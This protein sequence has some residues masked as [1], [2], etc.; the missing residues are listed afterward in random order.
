MHF[1]HLPSSHNVYLNQ[2]CSIIGRGISLEKNRLQK[3][4]R[5]DIKNQ[6]LAECFNILGT[7]NHDNWIGVSKEHEKLENRNREDIYFYLD[8]D[9]RTR[10]FFVEGKRLPK[11]GTLT[12]EEYVKG[13]STT[14]NPSGG[15]ERFKLG[16]HG[17]PSQ[18]NCYG[19]IAYVEKNTIDS[20]LKIIN[21][22]IQKGFPSDTELKEEPHKLSD[23]F[24]THKLY[25]SP[26]NIN[27]YHFW[28]DLTRN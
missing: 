4:T 8:D 3:S 27:I 14:G 28:I 25:N 20:W 12:N 17:I 18:M 7:K 16:I 11:P 10:I 6:Q 26:A 19:I 15:I 24:S 1:D 22:S 5:E 13:T 21:A 2:I 9:N 23:F